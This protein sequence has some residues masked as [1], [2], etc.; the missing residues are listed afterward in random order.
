MSKI[1]SLLI[2]VV[3]TTSALIAAAPASAA[4]IVLTPASV[5]GDTGSYTFGSTGTTHHG[6][7]PAGRIFD[8]Q[9]GPIT[10][11]YTVGYW[12]NGD[13]G[14]ANA[15]IT[16][17]LGA[18]YNLTSFNLFNTSNGFN[19]DRGT[20]AFSIAASNAI[21]VAGANG[22]T[23]A[24]P[25]VT[26]ANGSLTAQSTSGFLTAQTFG[27][28]SGTAF[29]YLQFLPTSV[30]S[31]NQIVN[32][33]QNN[34]GLNELRVFGDRAAG[35]VPEPASWAMMIAGFSAIGFGLRNRRKHSLP[36]GYAGSEDRYYT[37]AV[38]L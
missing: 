35:A 9:T 32:G 8:Q 17:D 33:I 10:E 1:K 27:T 23:L 24:G 21:A 3:I 34:Y 16:I 26:I 37:K 36:V 29:R 11:V 2:G 19:G 12:I 13:N 30:A 20:G 38:N 18:A 14:P 22:F 31:A 5:I 7:Q 28:L 4:Q 25:I 15:F 6:D